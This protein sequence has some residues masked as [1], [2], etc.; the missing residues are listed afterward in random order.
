MSTSSTENEHDGLGTNL[1]L[2]IFVD[3][4]HRPKFL[5]FRRVCAWCT[6]HGGNCYPKV[7]DASGVVEMWRVRGDY[8]L[9]FG[10]ERDPKNGAGRLVRGC[11]CYSPLEV[12]ELSEEI[13]TAVVTDR[14][15]SI[16][17]VYHRRAQRGMKF[18]CVW[19]HPIDKRRLGPDQRRLCIAIHNLFTRMTIAHSEAQRRKLESIP[20][21]GVKSPWC[22]P[23][24]V[25]T[26]IS[27]SPAERR[28]GL[29][30]IHLRR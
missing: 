25:K 22:A 23:V 26:G 27:G 2:E 18:G 4:L 21:I 3:L 8:G 17:L 28:R 19:V 7:T 16:L 9:G 13:D 15:S 20:V 11:E 30:G 24:R 5:S 29:Q 10:R 6:A 1:R 14:P 12:T